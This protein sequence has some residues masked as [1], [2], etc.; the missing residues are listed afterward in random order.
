MIRPVACT[1]VLLLLAAC[2]GPRPPGYGVREISPVAVL[3]DPAGMS[4]YTYDRDARGKS[5]CHGDCAQS[6]PPALA[7]ADAQPVGGWSI[8]IRDDGQR[9]WAY[10]SRPLYTYVRDLR[11]GDAAG[12]RFNG[13]WNVANP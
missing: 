9:Q 3:T 5:N 13:V 4:L 11:P 12:H 1:A 7:A 2:V 10:K 6:W 8:I